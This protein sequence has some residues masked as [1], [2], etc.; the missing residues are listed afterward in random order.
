MSS[1]RTERSS[2]RE[3][4]LER[5]CVLIV[6]DEI[7]IRVAIG[8]YFARQGWDVR[9]APDGEA[10]QRLLEPNAGASFDVVICDLH[11]PRFSGFALY[12]WLAGARPDAAARVVFSSGDVESHDTAQFLQDARRPILPKP[13]DLRELGRVIDEVRTARAA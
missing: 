10:A 4:S 11:M 2:S 12:R 5:P 8:R 9:E 7:S 3:T 6:D 13:F 1:Q